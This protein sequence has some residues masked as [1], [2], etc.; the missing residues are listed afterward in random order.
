[1]TDLSPAAKAVLEELGIVRRGRGRAK[2]SHCVRGHELAGD[3]VRDYID[4]RGNRTRACR[5][6]AF[7][8]YKNRLIA[9]EA[10]CT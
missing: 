1:M 3:N 4:T 2:Q 7:I 5:A 6:C 8:R 10:Q 9:K